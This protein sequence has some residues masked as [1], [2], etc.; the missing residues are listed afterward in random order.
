MCDAAALMAPEK[1]TSNALL[2]KAFALRICE[3]SLTNI[4]PFKVIMGSGIAAMFGGSIA[5]PEK[6]SKSNPLPT[7]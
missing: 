5:V 6:A 4:A 3:F 1:A 7:P 2:T